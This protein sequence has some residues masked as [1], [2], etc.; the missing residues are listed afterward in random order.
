M[1]E[2]DNETQSYYGSYNIGDSG[3]GGASD[4]SKMSVPPT[5]RIKHL[6]KTVFF[7][8]REE[9]M[10]GWMETEQIKLHENL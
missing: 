10:A 3:I 2:H 7:Y 6:Y 8:S 5:A 4:G 1:T 9:A